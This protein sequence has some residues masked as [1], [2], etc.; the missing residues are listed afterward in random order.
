MKKIGLIGGTSPESTQL[1]Y[2]YLIRFSRENLDRHVYPEI[3]IYSV[4]FKEVMDLM[5]SGEFS[6]LAEKFSRIFK[7]MEEMGVGIGALTA[8]TMHLVFDMIDVDFELVHIVDAVAIEALRRGYKKLVLFGTKAT[9]ESSLYPSIA[10]KHGLEIVIPD[11][12]D[13]NTIND[14]I[15]SDLV[16]GNVSEEI[17]EKLK[18]IAQR[19]LENADAVILGCTELPLAMKNVGIPVLDSTEI[20]AW[21]IFR[22]AVGI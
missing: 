16:V 4:N 13:R 8:N 17:K 7:W 18:S 3:V 2:D 6:E 22:K 9:M 12:D 11:P 19:Y 21:Q 1:Y 5:S 20:H 14:V 15:F 10:R